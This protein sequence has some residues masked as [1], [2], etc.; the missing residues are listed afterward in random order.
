MRVCVDAGHGGR[1][2]GAVG[3]NPFTLEEKTVNL[4]IALLLEQELRARG[5]EVVMT[6]RRDWYVS[7]EARADFANRLDVDLFISVHANASF[8]PATEGM[9][10]FHFPGATISNRYGRSILGSM[11]RRFPDHLDRGV[12]EA[13]FAV[14]RLTDMPAV[15]VECEFITNPRQLR[16]LAAPDR[17]A[18]LARAI[19]DGVT[20]A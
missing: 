15:L 12:K 5:H 20:G 11:L 7:L 14:L 17:Q 13:N 1:D 18:A 10:V 2:S 16:F 19:A 9:E 4:A 8:D 3:T 6:R